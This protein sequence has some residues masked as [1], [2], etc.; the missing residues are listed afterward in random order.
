MKI[1]DILN[2]KAKKLSNQIDESY[3]IRNG[4]KIVVGDV[5]LRLEDGQYVLYKEDDV[6]GTY[7]SFI[8]AINS[9]RFLTRD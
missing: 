2:Q 9:M 5:G 3:F 7:D 1:V 6:V 4:N 8:P